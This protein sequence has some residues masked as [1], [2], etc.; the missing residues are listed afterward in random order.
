MGIVAPV[1]TAYFDLSAQGGEFFT[2]EDPLLGRLDTGGV[3]GLAGDIAQVIDGYGYDININ[4]GRDRDLDEIPAGTCRITFRNQDRSF[5]PAYTASAFFPNVTPGKRISVSI[6]GATIFDGSAEDWENQYDRSLQ[7]DASVLCVDALGLLARKDF[8]AWTTT[9]LETAGERI[10]SVL[11]RSEV[12]YAGGRDLDD[13]VEPLQDDAVSWGS[14]VLNYLQLVAKSDLGRLFASRA[15]VLTYRDRVS[16]AGSTAVLTFADDGTGLP[17][18]GVTKRSASELLYTRV[19]VDREGGTLQTVTDATAVEAF[20]VR[21]LS[22]GGLLLNTDAQSEALAEFLLGIYKQPDD[23][24]ATLAIYVSGYESQADQAAVAGLE[25]G[26]LVTVVW[27]PAGVGDP[28]D[29]LMVVEGVAHQLRFDDGH[30][31]TLSLSNASQQSAFI[32]DDPIFGILS[33]PT[34]SVLAF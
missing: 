10:G 31:M 29:E 6:Y 33:P 28:I 11:N 3:D 7:A 12:N 26:D 25:I 23:R 15:G 20:G 14:N 8:D 27:T 22:L 34:N 9:D 30:W 5:D 1:I 24:I 17:F 19:G 4:R 16:L 21:T 2:V 13:G 18:H 32:L